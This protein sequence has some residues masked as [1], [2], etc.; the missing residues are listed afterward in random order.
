MTGRALS[1]RR[2]FDDTIWDPL[3]SDE[4]LARGL[5][6]RLLLIWE[7]RFTSVTGIVS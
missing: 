5:D 4:V 7:S 2:C 3:D 1:S 6:G